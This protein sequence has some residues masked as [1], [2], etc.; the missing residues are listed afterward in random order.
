MK[1]KD[2]I[3]VAWSL[4]KD[5][6]NELIVEREIGENPYVDDPDAQGMM[7]ESLDASVHALWPLIS[8]TGYGGLMAY[9]GVIHG[10]LYAT[11]LDED[12]KDQD[13]VAWE[14]ARVIH[15]YVGSE[16]AA[17]DMPGIKMDA[18]SSPENKRI[19]AELI[20]FL[21]AAIDGDFE[22]A[23]SVTRSLRSVAGPLLFAN[24]DFDSMEDAEKRA[25]TEFLGSALA[26]SV[27]Q[28]V[29]DTVGVEDDDPE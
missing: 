24:G 2:R 7:A 13:G 29:I 20:A 28:Y 26:S 23:V 18:E 9:R 15:E 27:T 16:Q 11:T 14:V 22:D 3:K 5:G 21:G 12:S 8:C 1:F 19:D 17:M 25:V 10:I 6:A 4:L